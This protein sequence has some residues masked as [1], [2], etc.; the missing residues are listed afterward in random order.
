MML[1]IVLLN[2][3]LVMLVILIHYEFLFF[4]SRMMPKMKVKHRTRIIFGVLGGLIAHTVEIWVF[5]FAYYVALHYMHGMG[6]LTGNFDSTFLDCIYFS[7]TI[8]TTLGFGDIVPIGDIR[9]LTGIE[10]LAGLVLITWTAS[11]FYY[12]MH[13]YWR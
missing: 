12:K 6:E 1:H 13:K 4:L 10:S 11:F 9:F 7:F 5:A 8:F 2:S 3:F